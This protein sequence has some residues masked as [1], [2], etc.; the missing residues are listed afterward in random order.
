M[1]LYLL[2]YRYFSDVG[3]NFL[4]TVIVDFHFRFGVF[5]KA[6]NK[7]IYYTSGFDFVTEGTLFIL[8]MFLIN[9]GLLS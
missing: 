6:G 8:M 1:S 7:L 3:Q 4:D 5:L 2:F 9:V